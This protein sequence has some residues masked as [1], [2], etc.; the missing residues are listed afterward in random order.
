[1]GMF[2][3]AKPL[4]EKKPA[5]RKQSAEQVAM[6]GLA[7]FAKID[8]LIKSLEGVKET[9]DG[10]LKTE[11]MDH[12]I[13]EAGG[14]RPANFTAIDGQATASV[15]LK[16]RSTRSA[17]KPD[18]VEFLKKAGVPVEVVVTTPKL[19]GINPKYATDEK[20]LEKIEK[21]LTKTGLPEDLFVVQEE[22][23]A[24][25]ANEKSIEAV[26]AGNMDADVVRM[27]TTLAIKP[28]LEEV[29]VREL[30]DEVKQMVAPDTAKLRAVA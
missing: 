17:L 30:F 22:V 18:E 8:A 24:T 2:D 4:K 7:K 19:F 11:A 26:F 28:T 6:K 1:M 9:L 21:V 25:V 5:S 23:S 13:T 16:V 15:Q 14:R 29:A 20:M 3:S 10:E 27:V 12:F